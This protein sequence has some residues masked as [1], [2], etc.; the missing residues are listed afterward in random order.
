MRPPPPAT[1]LASRGSTFLIVPLLLSLDAGLL[2]LQVLCAVGSV[3]HKL[4]A[5]E[6][7]ARSWCCCWFGDSDKR[8]RRPLRLLA[9]LSLSLR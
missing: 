1:I 3:T 9:L 7:P 5:A 4:T 8:D 6:M 2:H